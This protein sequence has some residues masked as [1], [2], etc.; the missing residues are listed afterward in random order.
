MKG[1]IKCLCR[2]NSLL[3]K[4]MDRPPSFLSTA[5]NGLR[6]GYFLRENTDKRLE[7]LELFL[8]L[9]TIFGELCHGSIQL[10]YFAAQ[11]VYFVNISMLG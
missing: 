11:F 9:C 10:A 2:E 8:K 6:F 7:P 5:T 4:W 3:E 1:W